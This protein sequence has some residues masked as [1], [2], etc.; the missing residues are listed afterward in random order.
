M[1]IGIKTKFLGST[2]NRGARI[3]ATSSDGKR[4]TTAYAYKSTTRQN[5]ED[6][7]RVLLAER[8]LNSKLYTVEWADHYTHTVEV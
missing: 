7:A 3:A 2:N 6:A 5:H 4:I 8:G 1:Y